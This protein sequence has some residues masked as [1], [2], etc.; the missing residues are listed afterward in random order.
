MSCIKFCAINIYTVVLCWYVACIYCATLWFS[1]SVYHECI[2]FSESKPNIDDVLL[3][4]HFTK[5]PRLD[6]G[7]LQVGSTKACRLLVRNPQD[8]DQVLLSNLFKPFLQYC[9]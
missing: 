8:Y 1:I 9:L 3:L 6:F 2:Y 7:S 4:T 5:S